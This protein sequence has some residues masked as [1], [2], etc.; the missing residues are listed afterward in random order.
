[1][2]IY[3]MPIRQILAP[4]QATTQTFRLHQAKVV[5]VVIG[6]LLWGDVFSETARGVMYF[7]T[8]FFLFMH[9]DME[10]LLR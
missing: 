10:P 8:R 1:M 7:S 6:Q 2:L 9:I 5:C 4:A 3:L